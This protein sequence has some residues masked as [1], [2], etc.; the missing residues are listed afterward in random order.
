MAEQAAEKGLFREKLPKYIPQG[1][2]APL[3]AGDLRHD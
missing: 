3:I 1:L 2:K